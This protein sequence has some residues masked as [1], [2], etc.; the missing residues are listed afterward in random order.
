MIVLIAPV[1]DSDI[2]LASLLPEEMQLEDE[3]IQ[4]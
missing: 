4:A 1:D 3:Q 2:E